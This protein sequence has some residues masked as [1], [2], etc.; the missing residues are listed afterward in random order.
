MREAG[1]G[2][3]VNF[4]SITWKVGDGDCPAYVTAKAAVNGL[5]RALARELGPERIR[6]NSVMPGWVMTERQGR[7]WLTPE[8]ERPLDAAPWVP[9]RLY[10]AGIAHMVVFLAAGDGRMCSS[11]N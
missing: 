6:V 5:T 10:P 4:G 7:V 3:I 11:Q 9:G 2:S 1:G 8:G